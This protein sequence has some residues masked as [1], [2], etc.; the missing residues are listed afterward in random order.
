MKFLRY[1]TILAC[2]IGSPAHA[3]RFVDPA[4]PQADN[5]YDAFNQPF[6][7]PE[8]WRGQEF[9]SA[10]SA[11]EAVREIDRGRLRMFHR[12]HGET[13]SDFGIRAGG[14]RLHF[15][16]PETVERIQLLV[17]V[18]DLEVL[19]CPFNPSVARARATLQGFF[20][21]TGIPIPGSHTNDVSAQI[22]IA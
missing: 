17:H 21:N 5:M 12:I 4:D 1:V 8:R 14:T 18:T 16:E 7:D 11:T 19:D 22:E 3:I 13:D 10:L 9:G 15:T 2:F 6:I 20:F